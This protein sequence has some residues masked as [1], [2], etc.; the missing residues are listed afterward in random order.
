MHPSR[1]RIPRWLAAAI[2]AALISTT[3][4]LPAAAA[5]TT[6]DPAAAPA[7]AP[8]TT[9][10]ALITGDTVRLTHPG[11]GRY[12]A[13]PAASTGAAITFQDLGNHASGIRAVYAVPLAA[14]S[15]VTDGSLD[16]NLFDVTWLAS[17]P[18]TPITLQYAGRRAAGWLASRGAALAGARVTGTSAA[19]GTV[20]VRVAPGRAGV[21]WAALTGQHDDRDPGTSPA[22]PRLAGGIARAWPVGHRSPGNGQFAGQALYTVTE[23]IARKAGFRLHLP[24]LLGISGAGADTVSSPATWT[25]L[26]PG[27]VNCYRAQL[28]FRVPAGVYEADDPAG[29][30]IDS[31][32]MLNF[33]DLTVPQFTVAGD[34][35]IS[36]DADKAS[37]VTIGTPLPSMAYTLSSVHYRTLADGTF[38]SDTTIPTEFGLENLWILPTARAVTIGSF[39]YD[40]EWT[41]GAPPVTMSVRGPGGFP[42]HPMY[43]DYNPQRSTTAPI[44]RRFSGRQTLPLVAAGTGTRKDFSQVDAHGKLVLLK[45]SPGSICTI[46]KWQLDNAKQAGAVGV[47]FDP[48]DPI[49]APTDICGQPLTLYSAGEGAL[50]YVRVPATEAAK[51]DSLLAAGQVR[52]TV[53]DNGQSPYIYNL[54]FYQEGHVSGSGHYTVAN[55]QL[56][57]VQARYHSAT[58]QSMALATFAFRPSDVTLTGTSYAFR[59]PCIQ[60]EY[61]GPASP[62]LVWNRQLYTTTTT[63]PDQSTLDVFTA[64]PTTS[65]WY[66][67]PLAPG[68]AAVASDAAQAQP[69]RYQDRCSVCRQDDLLDPSLVLPSGTDPRIRELYIPAS[70]HLYTASGTEIQPTTDHGVTVYQMP[71]ERGWYKLVTSDPSISTSWRFSSARPDAGNAPQVDPCAGTLFGFSASPCAAQPLIFLR[72]N[73]ST[74]LSNAVT[75]P[76]THTLQ[77]TP[78]YQAVTAPARITSLKLWT[79]ADGGKTWQPAVIHKTAGSS[80]TA[81]YQVPALSSTTGTISIKTQASDSAGDTVNQAILN[82][83]NLT[84]TH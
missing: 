55:Q 16:R 74:S 18:D 35:K 33:V 79:S 69:T 57:Q 22:H 32:S 10:V 30:F 82:A 11:P 75:A 25:C 8:V 48:R 43:W 52:I 62:D 49:L 78:Y 21:F 61:Y 24:D 9:T 44:F 41:L 20:T 83:Y 51:L 36:I 84:S 45:V 26:E 54:K 31:D 39:H 71:A 13:V 46:P 19:E 15:L 29:D 66:T 65:D 50:P 60:R 37:R 23:T 4:A 28:T 58:A 1:P 5:H 70:T 17:H 80:Y 63:A 68:A 40:S 38:Y 81:A 14:A 59:V 64:G 3:F 56:A 12:T 67:A 27:P 42:L 73:A 2:P 53:T 7:T 76:G 47:L 77:I 6:A 34:T 72:Y